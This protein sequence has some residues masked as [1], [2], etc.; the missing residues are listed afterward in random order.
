MKQ[1]N[2]LDLAQPVTG[3]IKMNIFF[4]REFPT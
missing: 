1:T 4:S 3:T 2:T